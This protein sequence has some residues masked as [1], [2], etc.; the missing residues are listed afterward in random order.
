MAIIYIPKVCP[1]LS[2]K[3]KLEVKINNVQGRVSL[4]ASCPGC[5]LCSLQSEP[6]QLKVADT[7]STG[8][9]L[10]PKGGLLQCSMHAQASQLAYNAVTDLG[11]SCIDMSVED[12]ISRIVSKVICC[13]IRHHSYEATKKVARQS[14]RSFLQLRK[15]APAFRLKG[16]LYG[17]RSCCGWRSG[18]IHQGP[19]M[20]CK[21]NPQL[22][23]ARAR[24]G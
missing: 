19:I 7:S 20:P 22:Q 11:L 2:S 24:G 9:F 15:L 6:D 23:R 16:C 18:F 10:N 21:S 3:L 14:L 12:R 8:L 1:I 5:S 13:Q 17:S 4:A